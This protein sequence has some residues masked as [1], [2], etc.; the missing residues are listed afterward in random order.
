MWCVYG[1]KGGGFY[2]HDHVVTDAMITSELI[3]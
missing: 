3:S 2:D 1:E